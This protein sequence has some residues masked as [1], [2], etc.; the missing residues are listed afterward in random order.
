MTTD[1]MDASDAI[2]RQTQS[3][4]GTT[5]SS[6]LT[7]ET[8]LFGAQEIDNV[9]EKMLESLQKKEHELCLASQMGETLLAK[10]Q[11]TESQVEELKEENIVLAKKLSS[12]AALKRHMS[13][14]ESSLQD[15]GAVDDESDLAGENASLKQELSNSRKELTHIKSEY[16]MLDDHRNELLKKLEERID[17][18]SWVSSLASKNHDLETHNRNLEGEQRMLRTE[19]LDL[20]TKNATLREENEILRAKVD[21]LMALSKATKVQLA[22]AKD[23]SRDLEVQLAET[24]SKM[25]AL[26]GPR[27]DS[28]SMAD[29]PM[30]FHFHMLFQGCKVMLTANAGK[31]GFAM[32]CF[33]GLQSSDMYA[34]LQLASPPVPFYEWTQWIKEECTKLYVEHLYE[35]SLKMNPVSETAKKA[36]MLRQQGLISQEELRR[37]MAADKEFRVAELLT[38]SPLVY[39]KEQADQHSKKVAQDRIKEAKAAKL[40]YYI[41]PKS[42]RRKKTQRSR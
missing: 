4:L 8:L 21:D 37:I 7:A 32:D 35:R 3:A 13:T 22:E 39:M 34:T 25:K 27:V 2:L 40:N 14:G 31:E 30:A 36:N 5:S 11:K 15:G 10:L 16:S 1:V 20:E 41:K 6:V 29:D 18:G 26:S 38:D 33:N 24:R 12:S 23:K 17:V 9:V 19:S 42:L 28:R